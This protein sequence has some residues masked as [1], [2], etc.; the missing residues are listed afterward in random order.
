MCISGPHQCAFYKRLS[1]KKKIEIKNKTETL[2][3]E[4]MYSCPIKIHDTGAVPFQM[5]AYTFVPKWCILVM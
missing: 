4:I 3:G 2:K 5:L 1:Y